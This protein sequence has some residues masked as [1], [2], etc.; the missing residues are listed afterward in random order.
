[1]AG[2]IVSALLVIALLK[3]ARW[4]SRW[5]A[6]HWLFDYSHGFVRRGLVGQVLHAVT[7]S[8]FFHYRAL[9]LLCLVVLV[10]DVAAIVVLARRASPAASPL[11][12]PLL[13]TVFA[14]STGAVFLVHAIGYLDQVALGLVLAACLLLPHA[15]GA[16][17]PSALVATTAA[18][19]VLVHEGQALVALPLLLWAAW[20]RAVLPPSVVPAAS[21]LRA[22]FARHGPWVLGAAAASLAGWLVNGRGTRSP[23]ALQAL[24]DSLAARADFPLRADA[25]AAVDHPIKDNVFNVMAHHWGDDHTYL[26][27]SV[28]LGLP[29]S[30]FFVATGLLVV[31]RLGASRMRRIGLGVGFL[32]ASTSPWALNLFGWDSM[33]WSALAV[34]SAFLALLLLVSVAPPVATRPPRAWW[35]TA[36]VLVIVLGLVSDHATFLFDDERVRWFPFLEVWRALAQAARAPHLAP[37]PH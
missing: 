9:A 2:V 27:V 4:P 29:A 15:R 36:A 20:L 37:P 10:L 1:M 26:L 28:L 16:V 5:A 33:R 7:G 30:L 3:G 6:T 23:E 25:F 31:R 14:S 24:R 13:L 35:A 11:L 34:T 21:R 19:V 17:L 8:L 32:L 22:T 18:V 12:G